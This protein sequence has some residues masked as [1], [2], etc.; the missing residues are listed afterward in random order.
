[1]PGY[2]TEA[3]VIYGRRLDNSSPGGAVNIVG[4]QVQWEQLFLLPCVKARSAY[5]SI[6]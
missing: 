1:M 4:C 3:S 2:A 6:E 5:Q